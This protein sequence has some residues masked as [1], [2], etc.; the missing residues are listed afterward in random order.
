MSDNGFIW[1]GDIGCL[2]CG[3]WVDV[4]G[5][6][7]GGD[8][9]L[10]V[11]GLCGE[12]GKGKM[13]FVICFVVVKWFVVWCGDCDGVI[14]FGGVVDIGVI[15]INYYVFWYFWCGIVWSDNC[16]GGVFV[17]CDIGGGSDKC[18]VV[19]LCCI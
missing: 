2:C 4:V 19:S 13:I 18:L 5:V 7:G 8:G 12:E 1:G 17:F 14:W 3:W 11:V 16:C 6:V 9:N 15:F 10:F